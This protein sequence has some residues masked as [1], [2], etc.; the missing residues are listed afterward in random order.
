MSSTQRIESLVQKFSTFQNWEERYKYII[1]CGKEL[2]P[3]SEE[4]RTEQNIVRGCQSQVWLHADLIDGK[5]IYQADSDASIVK[6]IIT[7]LLEVY[8]GLAPQEILDCPPTWLE[9]IELKQHLSMSRANGLAS[10]IKQ[11]SLYAMAFQAKQNM[12]KLV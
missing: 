3:I 11:I 4:H 2:A 1:Q 10:M 6:G 9:E 7:L 5:I 8:S 12:E